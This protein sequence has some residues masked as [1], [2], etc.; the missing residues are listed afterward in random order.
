MDN[1]LTAKIAIDNAIGRDNAMKVENRK[2]VKANSQLKN[3]AIQS[4]FADVD[5][6]GEIDEVVTVR[7]CKNCR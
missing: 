2:S 6:C 7:C 5:V 1:E 4:V 3:W